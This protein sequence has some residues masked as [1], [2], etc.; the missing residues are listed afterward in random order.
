MIREHCT[1]LNQWS[2]NL[3]ITIIWNTFKRTCCFEALTLSLFTFVLCNLSCITRVK[4]YRTSMSI[5]CDPMTITLENYPGYC[6][7][8]STCTFH[9]NS[10]YSWLSWLQTEGPF[11]PTSSVSCNSPPSF[12]YIFHWQFEPAFL[13]MLYLLV[14]NLSPPAM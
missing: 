13:F 5:P 2:S 9:C 4:N 8:L 14:W 10:Y 3:G 12:G 7:R 11:P 1:N 6:I